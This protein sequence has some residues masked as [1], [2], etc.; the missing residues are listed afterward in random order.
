MMQ[1]WLQKVQC[2]QKTFSPSFFQNISNI[3]SASMGKS[4]KLLKGMFLVI[5]IGNVN[6]IR[7]CE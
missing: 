7:S 3:S 4:K 2:Y 6:S 1:L 5:L